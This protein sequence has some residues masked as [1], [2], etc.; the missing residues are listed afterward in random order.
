MLNKALIF[1]LNWRININYS[2]EVTQRVR[3]HLWRTWEGEVLGLK[4]SS[5]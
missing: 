4:S 1:G 5:V 2:A 3:H